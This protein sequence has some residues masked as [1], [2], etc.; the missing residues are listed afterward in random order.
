V[1]W[2]SLTYIPKDVLEKIRKL[3][4]NSFGHPGFIARMV[5]RTV[6][7][8]PHPDSIIPISDVLAHCDKARRIGA[9]LEWDPPHECVSERLGLA[10]S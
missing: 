6:C 4:L 7:S 1:F 9:P 8:P 3:C 10:K 5:G 2:H